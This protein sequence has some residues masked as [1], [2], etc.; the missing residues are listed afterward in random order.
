[1][2][3]YDIVIIGAGPA[4]LTAGLYAGRAGLN[5]LI[6]EKIS[7]GGRVLFT[8]KIE[9]FPGV[10]KE[11]S[12]S[13]LIKNMEDQIRQFNNVEIV[14]D[15]VKDIDTELKKIFTL[16]NTYETLSIIV[17]TGA[18]SKKLGIK[19]EDE[20]L[21][22]GVSY[23]AICDGPLYRDKEVAIVGGGDSAIKEALFLS[24]FCKKVNII[25]R[26]NILRASPLLQDKLI[27]EPNIEL[28]LNSRVLEIRG[29][30]KMEEILIEDLTTGNSNL[31][32]CAGI[33]I[34]VGLQPNT[35]FLRGKISLDE[36]GFILTD[37][38]MLTSR[39]GIFA[40]GDCRRKS[41]YQIITACSE[42]AIASNSAENYINSI[43]K[44]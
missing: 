18:R 36:E 33:F 16:H 27:R 42:G 19:G 8:E 3:K 14:F 29:K 4:G 13:D 11:I 26:R 43:K 17:A 32:K 40:C 7:L 39:E 6:L 38:N 24:R 9:N 22:R 20:F 28:I 15:E 41:L 23:C 12:S 2:F 34:Y 25:H 1:M 5:T 31:L 30:D 44:F 21:G 10:G 37:E 35:E